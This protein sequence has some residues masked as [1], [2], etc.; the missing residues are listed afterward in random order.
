MLRPNRK[1]WLSAFSFR[2]KIAT[3]TLLS[4]LFGYGLLISLH[5]SLLG[6]FLYLALWG[7][8][9]F[10]I[11]INACR[12]CPYY[13]KKCPVPLEGDCVQLFFGKS[14]KAF[15]WTSLVW[16]LIAYCLRIALPTVIMIIEDK[17]VAGVFYYGLF[18]LFWF[19]H[20]RVAGCPN[21]IN[22][23]CPLNPDYPPPS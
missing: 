5:F 16:A 7:L 13:G 20:L 19:V 17:G 23:A 9:F 2:E 14:E 8:S 1:K 4:A 12:R 6:F 15:G 21:C 18:A 3:L 11:Y 10:L 22:T